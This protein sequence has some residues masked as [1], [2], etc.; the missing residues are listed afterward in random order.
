[1]CVHDNGSESIPGR[2]WRGF[3]RSPRKA[4]KRKPS[5]AFAF[6]RRLSTNPRFRS[7]PLQH[8]FCLLY[9]AL[10]YAD[11]AGKF[12]TSVPRWC[13]DVKTSDSMIRRT[14]R[15]AEQVGLLHR[16]PYGRP[17]GSQ[18]SNTYRF[19]LS[20]L[21]KGEQ[22]C[23]DEATD[24]LTRMVASEDPEQNGFKGGASR[25][26]QLK[27]NERNTSGAA[28]LKELTAPK[29]VSSDHVSDISAPRSVADAA[30][31][32]AHSSAASLAARSGDR[33]PVADE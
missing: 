9:A 23:L 13:A 18:G 24:S 6:I 32:F 31:I 26:H 7:L 28:S 14:V 29:D 16:D 20:P 25:P 11:G 27:A 17:D 10:H 22:P 33:T 12:W 15:A 30:V 1:M 5:E 21:I 8:R 2:D 3:T 19:D 4:A